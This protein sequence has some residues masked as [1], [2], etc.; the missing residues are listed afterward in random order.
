VKSRILFEQMLGRGTRRSTDLLPP[1]T[2]FV[3]FDCFNG[4]LIEYFRKT[5]GM[6]VEPPEGDRK[7]I[8]EIIDDIWQNRDRDYNIRRLVKRLQRIAKDMSGDARDLFARFI[9][10]G[11]MGRF[12]EDLP[13]TLR[14]DFSG[15]MKILRDKDFQKLLTEYPR[16]KRTFIVAP[17]SRRS[18]LTPCM[19][20]CSAAT[21]ARG[22][23]RR[24][25]AGPRY[26]SLRPNRYGRFTTRCLTT[27]A[28]RFC[29]ARSPAYG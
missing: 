21:R 4:T 14:A 26:T 10:D 23:L 7:S 9:P 17:G 3:V 2:N 24:R 11:D 13:S 29:S 25:W 15:A 28:S 27:S 16:A 1:K 8:V 20:V 5:T 6:T 22:G 18:C 12:A 19:T